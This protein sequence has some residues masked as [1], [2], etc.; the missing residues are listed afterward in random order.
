MSHPYTKL[1]R[2]APSGTVSLAAVV[3]FAAAACSRSQPRRAT[4]PPGVIPQESRDV[5]AQR[6]ANSHGADGRGDGPAAPALNPRPRDYTDRAWQASVADDQ[7]AAV[8]VDGGASAGK[9][10]LMPPNPDLA[11][12]PD[13]VEGLVRIVR[14]YGR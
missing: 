13:V 8:I 7:I 6:C 3:L 14:S 2:V 5:F 10:T 11:S 9:S 4:L 1:G 12:K